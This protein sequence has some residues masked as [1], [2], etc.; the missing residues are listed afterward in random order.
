MLR[1]R[2]ENADKPRMPRQKN[3]QRLFCLKKQR[4]Q[5]EDKQQTLFFVKIKYPYPS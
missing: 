5:Q 4:P 1:S 2:V 3:V